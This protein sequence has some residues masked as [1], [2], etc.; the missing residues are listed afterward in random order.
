MKI[1]GA[2]FLL[3]LLAATFV[4]AEPISRFQWK[5]IQ[6]LKGIPSSQGLNNPSLYIFF[7]PNCAASARLFS[8]TVNGALFEKLD[9]VWIPVNS[10]GGSSLGKSISIL[11]GAD[12]SLIKKNFLSFNFKNDFGAMKESQVSNDEASEIQRSI[13]VWQSLSSLG[14]PLIAYRDKEG[15]YGIHLGYKPQT[16]IETIVA[17]LGGSKIAPY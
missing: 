6:D 1:G 13:G 5:K 15:R 12:F 11:K 7:D 17:G 2:I 9:S 3:F 14:T 4:N 16:E 10:M 8:M